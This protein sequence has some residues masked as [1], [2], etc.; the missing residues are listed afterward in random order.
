MMDLLVIYSNRFGIL[1]MT[2]NS[3]PQQRI[4]NYYNN[5]MINQITGDTIYLNAFLLN[6]IAQKK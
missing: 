5:N 6:F 2:I 4:V 1:D 3:P